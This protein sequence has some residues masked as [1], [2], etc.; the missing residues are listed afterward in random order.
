MDILDAVK[1][2]KISHIN[3]LS[4]DNEEVVICFEDDSLLYFYHEQDCCENVW[5]EDFE[6][7]GKDLD[8]STL[9]D[10][11]SV[12]EDGETEWGT[13]T[14]T[15]YT[16]QTTKGELWMRWNGESNGYYSEQINMKYYCPS[17]DALINVYRY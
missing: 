3:G 12:T 2:K 4:K 16:V 17:E 15:F 13:Y 8:G 9:L 6:L 5:L 10:V 11:I 14:W 7:S 1:G